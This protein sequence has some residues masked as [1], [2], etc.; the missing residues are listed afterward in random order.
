MNTQWIWRII[1]IIFIGSITFVVATFSEAAK[2]VNFLQDNEVVLKENKQALIAATVIAN[3]HN[4]TDV[5]VLKDPLYQQTFEQTSTSLTVSIYPL[6][7]FKEG[8][9]TNAIAILVTDLD[10][11]DT[12]AKT[13]DNDEHIIY[14]ELVFDR[15]LD[16]SNADKR[17]FTEYMTP[18][19]DNSGRMIII[20]QDV[21]MTSSGQA[22]FQTL[23]FSYEVQSG[24]KITVVVLA[25]SNLVTDQ[26]SDIFDQSIPR[27]IAALTEENLDLVTQ[28]GTENLTQ[29]TAIYYD[30]SWLEKLNSYNYIYVRNVLIEFA[31]VLPI[32]YFLFFHKY[33][34]RRIRL[35]RQ[36]QSTGT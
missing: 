16:V 34:L 30:A 33:V 10:I 14:T 3:E 26:P 25:N 7:K 32:T 29:N 35:N 1:Y 12:L 21:L 22:I 27:D 18:L 4:G 28:F 20:N 19:F 24:D 31:I 11:K 8:L 2:V 36:H 15:D 5:Y 13:D 9:S 17:L 23:S 6:V